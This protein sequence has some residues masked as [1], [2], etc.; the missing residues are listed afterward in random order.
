M[1]LCNATKPAPSLAL[2]ILEAETAYYKEVESAS[3][4]L[5]MFSSHFFV[6]SDGHFNTEFKTCK[7]ASFDRDMLRPLK[8][9]GTRCSRLN[10]IGTDRCH[11]LI[12]R[13]GAECGESR[14]IRIRT[15]LSSV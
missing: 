10:Q 8:N 4:A 3:C 2:A 9:A 7:Y 11:Y 5:S 14:D 1:Q 15:G 6:L 13:S 12:Q